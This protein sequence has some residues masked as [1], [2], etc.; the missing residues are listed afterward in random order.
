VGSVTIYSVLIFYL[1]FFSGP[2]GTMRYKV[3]ILP[4]LIF[5]IPFLLEKIK[6]RFGKQKTNKIENT[7][8]Y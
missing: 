4:L 7:I 1:C 2:L 5:T 8:S 6:R 3:H